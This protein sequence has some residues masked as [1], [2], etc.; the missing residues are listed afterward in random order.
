MVVISGKLNN[1][2][3]DVSERTIRLN[4]F[5]AQDI[6]YAASNGTI[7]TPESVLF[8]TV[9]KSLCNNTEVV[10]IINQYRHGISYDKVEEIET[11]YALKVTDEQKQSRVTIPEGVT[12]NS[13]DSSVALM[14]AD[15]ID[16]FENTMT[17][18]GTSHRVNSILVTMKTPETNEEAEEDEEEYCP[19]TK[20]KCGRS[21][22]PEAVSSKIPDYYGG[23]RVGPGKLNEIKNL[24][25]SCSYLN[26]RDSEIEI[27]CLDRSAK[28]KNTP[29]IACS[30]L[31]G[32]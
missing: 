13:C 16:N 26:L 24:S 32:I 1:G 22:P 4:N 17:G 14:V 18:S 31:D 11:A 29:N 12:A 21:L 2:D 6:V 10:K 9:V 23:K 20:R 28:V 5:V 15:N 25:Q 3:S 8:P 7:K 30:W 27:H 19:L